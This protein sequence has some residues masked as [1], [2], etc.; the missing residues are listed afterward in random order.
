MEVANT[1]AYYDTATVTALKSFIV[2]APG[3]ILSIGNLNQWVASLGYSKVSISDLKFSKFHFCSSIQI[4]SDKHS[5]LL[6]S[7]ISYHENGNL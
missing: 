5:N 3:V 4:A 1:L 7:F 2:K 6:G